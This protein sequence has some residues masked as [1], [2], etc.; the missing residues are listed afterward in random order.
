MRR[1]E[2]IAFLGGAATASIARPLAA[3]AQHPT[4]PVV[5]FLNSASQDLSAHDVHAF[6]LGLTATELL[7]A[8]IANPDL[9]PAAP[10]VIVPIELVHPQN[11]SLM[12]QVTEQRVRPA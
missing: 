6:R 3:H 8:R 5:G 7:H 1:R 2:F 10:E 11:Q 9:T 4:M 12:E